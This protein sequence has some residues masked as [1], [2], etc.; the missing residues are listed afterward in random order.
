MNDMQYQM[1]SFMPYNNQNNYSYNTELIKEL[2]KINHE[3]IKIE[4]RLDIIENSLKTKTS[5]YLSSNVSDQKG[6]Y[7]L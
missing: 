3:L 4:K 5:N 1:P 6:L 2:E 7:M